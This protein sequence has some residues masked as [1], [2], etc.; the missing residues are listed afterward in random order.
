MDRRHDGGGDAAL[1]AAD[2]GR[3]SGAPEAQDVERE[4][5]EQREEEADDGPADQSDPARAQHGS[6]QSPRFTVSYNHAA[7]GF[8]NGNVY[9]FRRFAVSR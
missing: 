8:G 9:Y 3:D 7:V 6:K 2:C 4:A 1:A 5:E